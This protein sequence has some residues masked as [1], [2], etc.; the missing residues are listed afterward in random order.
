MIV[1]AVLLD[2]SA[3]F[4]VIDHKLL[5]KK[6]T[7]RWLRVIY[8]IEPRKCSSR[9]AILNVRYGPP[10]SCLGPL[11]F[12]IFTNDL[13][14]V[15]HKATNTIYVDD[16]TLYMPAPKARELTEILNKKLQISIRMGMGLKYIYI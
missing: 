3:A 11:L 16:S 13:P 1:G 9:E 7:L 5:L 8:Q 14:L 2:F 12:S 15:L 6:L 10:G 4:D